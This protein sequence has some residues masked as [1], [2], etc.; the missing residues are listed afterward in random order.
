MKVRFLR[1]CF[2]TGKKEGAVWEC[3]YEEAI[4]AVQ[5]GKAEFVIDA[6]KKSKK[7]VEVD[8]SAAVEGGE[9]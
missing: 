4:L 6:P 9:A 3:S 5:H 2:D 7:K 1:D 8:E